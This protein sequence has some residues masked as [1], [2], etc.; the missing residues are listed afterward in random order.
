MIRS[1][2]RAVVAAASIAG[3]A[4][5]VVLPDAVVEPVCGN[6]VVEAGEQCDVDSPG[7]ASCAVVP[8]WTCQGA[9]CA[10]ICGDGVTCGTP[11]RE[12]DCDVTGYWAAR[13]TNGT[14]ESV[15]GSLQ[16]ASNWF[17]YRLEQVGED[18]VVAESLDCGVRVT[19]TA[20][21]DYTPGTLRGLLYRSRMDA[22]SPRGPRRGRARPES[23]GCAIS[24]DRWYKVRGLSEGY[25]PPDFAEKPP[26]SSLTPLPA[27]ADAVT[28]REFPAG[29]EDPD[30]DG[31]PGAAYQVA[32]IANGVRNSAQR[33]WKEFGTLPGTTVPAG[34]LSFELPGAFELEES[35]LRVTDCGT[36]CGLLTAAARVAEDV[37]PRLV[38]AYLG[39]SLGGP[40]VSQVV[41]G[42]PRQSLEADLTTCA[43]VR[44]VLPHPTGAGR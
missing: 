44:L 36:S 10:P 28:N 12:R 7:C 41:A 5:D 35:I 20:T 19:G 15:L 31:L 4:S 23:G 21:V 13:E 16:T 14:R 22:A 18:F 32:G 17:L 11:R 43:R 6:G 34:T 1:W 9:S 25:L 2:V 29:A 33:D 40:R 42:P 30:G 37:T 27:V 26:L 3:C 39:A 24:L 8:T 38:L